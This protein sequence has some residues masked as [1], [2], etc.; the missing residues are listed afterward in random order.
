VVRRSFTP[1]ISNRLREPNR[2]FGAI[3]FQSNGLT[4]YLEISR[5]MLG[6]T[7]GR[8]YS[9]ARKKNAVW[10]PGA[11]QPFTNDIKSLVSPFVWKCK[12]AHARSGIPIRKAVLTRRQY[13]ELLGS[14]TLGVAHD[15]H[16]GGK[17]TDVKNAIRL[18]RC[19][20]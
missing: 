4:E 8:G 2:E 11:V 7:E 6:M 3:G 20:C 9:L 1:G 14:P 13:L 18:L 12:I 10:L 15:V 19:R 17:G 16:T 5:L